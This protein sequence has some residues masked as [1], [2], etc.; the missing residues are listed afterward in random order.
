MDKNQQKVLKR[1]RLIWRLIYGP[2][3]L[4]CRIMFRYDFD[5]APDIPPSSSGAYIVLPNHSNSWDHFFAAL[6]FGPRRHM[7]FLASEHTFRKPFW[8]RLMSW[9]AGPISRTKGGADASAVMSVLR[10]L[11]QGV[12]VCIF[13]EGE[14]T[15]DGRTGAMHP[16]TAKLLKMSGVPIVTYRI[17]G[18]YLSLPRWSR[19]RRTG[20]MHGQVVGIYPPEQIRKMSTDEIDGLLMRD[21][22]VNAFEQQKAEPVIYK[23]KK[24]AEGLEEALFLCPKCGA[25]D[26]ARGTGNVFSCSCGMSAHFGEDGFFDSGAPFPSIAAWDD[27]QTE[28]LSDMCRSGGPIFS[29]DGAELWELNAGHQM[30]LCAKGRASL[31]ADGLH[32]NEF[33]PLSGFGA[34]SLCHFSGYETMMFSHSGRQYELRLPNTVS[35]RKYRL[36]LLSLLSQ[37]AETE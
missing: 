1:H 31:D 6:A 35:I 33:Y 19:S 9:L 28:R 24:R 37:R 10:Y 23:G 4:L 7:Y 15:F 18:G 8:S 34:P 12:S 26:S 29:D 21:L 5:P 22:Y 20:K 30:T 2:V 13:P 36:A 14:N 32:L 16:A 27:W 25:V 3:Q 17:T 11:K